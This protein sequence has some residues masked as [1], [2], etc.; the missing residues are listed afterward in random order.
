MISSTEMQNPFQQPPQEVPNSQIP[1]INQQPLPTPPKIIP[2]MTIS[3]FFNEPFLSDAVLKCPDMEFPFHKVVLC[4]ASKFIYDYFKQIQGQKIEDKTVIPLPEQIV[5]EFSKG[6]PKESLEKV[7]RYCYAN[8]NYDTIKDEITEN[9]IFTVLSYAHCLGIKS[10]VQHLE[11]AI[12]K[13]VVNENNV[14]KVL[15]DAILY[16]MPQ[17]KDVCLNKIKGIYGKINEGEKKNILDFNFDMFKAM[18]SSDDIEVANE[19]EICQLVEEYIKDRRAL[20]PVEEKK[21]EEE[22]KEE[23]KKEEEKKEEE[24]KEEEKKEEEKKEGEEEEKKEGEEE[25]KKEGEEEEKKEEEKK[26]GEE[27]KKEEEKKEEEKK[28]GEEEK[29]EEEKNEEPKKME[30]VPEEAKES[31]A[32]LPNRN[33]TEL[34]DSWKNHLTSIKAYLQK[35]SLTPEQER[36][37]ILCIRFSFLSHSDLVGYTTNP[38]IGQ[39][40]DLLLEGLSVRLNTYESASQGP[41]Q[42]NL[43]PRKFYINPLST[44]TNQM[45][46]S[47]Q[48]DPNNQNNRYSPN[49][50]MM[51]HKDAPYESNQI[52]Q[53]NNSRDQ[54]YQSHNMNSNIP[55]NQEMYQSS[56]IN[57][58]LGNTNMSGLKQTNFNSQLKYFNNHLKTDTESHT[59]YNKTQSQFDYNNQDIINVEDMNTTRGR[60]TNLLKSVPNPRPPQ[61]PKISMEFYKN[62]SVMNRPRPIFKYEYDFDENGVFF[63]LG[64][65]GKLSPYRNPHEIGQVKVFASSLGKGQLGD[66]VGRNLVNLRTLN[67]ENSFFGVDLGEERFLIPSA[68]SIRNRN[69][70]SHVMLCWN[71]EGSNDKMNFEVLDTRIFSN[72]TNSKY[73]QNLEKERNLLK[74]P[75]CT[76]TWGVSKKIREKFPNGFRYFIVKQIDK[77]SSGGYNMAISGFELYGE[78]VGK[79]WSFN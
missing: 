75:G 70:S 36:E 67:E 69:S 13:N 64:T 8:Q 25:E 31:E 4:A 73:H 17:L 60:K 51:N 74:Q 28:E 46:Q 53:M 7:I 68:Y 58:N 33:P 42:I 26:D 11:Q 45:V 20:A 63:H 15:N 54:M 6:N 1:I 10:L 41:L 57:Q 72:N 48:L 35:K 62:M 71:L 21:P 23:E 78:G 59:N 43:T 79:N 61:D 52:N 32:T 50:S 16:E 44:T 2:E 24:K 37:L 34:F 55:R 29:K 12:M 65:M 9:N 40:K 77:N 38:I 66:F 19:K 56:T 18:I 49:N 39:H 30:T 3:S 5:S 47:N 27:E 14:T 76:S 22:K